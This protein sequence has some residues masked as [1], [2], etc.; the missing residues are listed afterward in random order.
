MSPPGRASDPSASDA[1]TDRPSTRPADR[2]DARPAGWLVVVVVSAVG[3]VPWSVQRFTTGELF[4][5]FAWGG[6]SF[7]P[8]FVVAPLWTYPVAS[9]PLLT[10]WTVAT[11]CWLAAVASAL[12]GL[13]GRE[14]A[15][16]TAGLL[17]VAAAVNLLVAVSFGVQPGR[18]AYPTGSLA[19]LFV[20]GWRLSVAR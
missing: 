2:S 11:G 18:V 5:R 1:A 17:G 12:T 15:R 10:Q 9:A 4:L 7:E 3:L 13:A 16:L 19:A 14:D 8:A 20:A 6:V